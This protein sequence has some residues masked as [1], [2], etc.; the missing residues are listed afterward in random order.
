MHK[1]ICVIEIWIFYVHELGGVVENNH[2]S[3]RNR[4]PHDCMGAML[5]KGCNFRENRYVEIEKTGCV[6]Q[7]Y[8][9]DFSLSCSCVGARA[10]NVENLKARKRL[11]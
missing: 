8:G 2:F 11:K 4:V 7:E 6:I 1:L 5:L 10:M 3:K 9:L